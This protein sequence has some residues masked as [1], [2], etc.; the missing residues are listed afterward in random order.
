MTY[1][2]TYPRQTNASRE[3]IFVKFKSA[4]FIR[5]YSVMHN[6]LI[7]TF[8]PLIKI[9]VTTFNCIGRTFNI[10]FITWENYM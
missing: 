3:V 10:Y 2:H 9:K 5:V 1:I 4:T 8:F 6:T 7:W